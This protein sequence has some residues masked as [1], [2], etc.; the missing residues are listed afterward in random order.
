MRLG[1]SQWHSGCG[2]LTVQYL[3]RQGLGPPQEV[4]ILFVDPTHKLTK[5]SVFLR[6]LRL[7]DLLQGDLWWSR[8]LTCHC[9][10][11][12]LL[13]RHRCPCCH[14]LERHGH[15]LVLPP[16][17]EFA[18]VEL[19]LCEGVVSRSCHPPT[20]YC[21]HCHLPTDHSQSALLPYLT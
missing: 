8:D 7:Q 9:H 15:L 14:L 18:S 21:H 11:L 2:I 16:L 6:I 4:M 3:R 17:Q 12:Y 13:D 5:S 20:R 10:L 1:H 19:G